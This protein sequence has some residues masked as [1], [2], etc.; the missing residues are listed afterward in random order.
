VQITPLKNLKYA[1][2]LGS[3]AKILFKNLD[4]HTTLLMLPSGVKKFFSIHSIAF[5][6]SF[7]EANLRQVDPRAGYWRNYGKK[8]KVRGVAMNPVDHPHGGR[9]KAIKYPRTP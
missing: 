4:H 8:S 3:L 6:N 5:L 7:K 9:T 2:S 1:K